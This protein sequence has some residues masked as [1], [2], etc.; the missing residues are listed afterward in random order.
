MRRHAG[1]RRCFASALSTA[2]VAYVQRIT[3]VA[4][5]QQALPPPKAAVAFVQGTAGVA[6]YQKFVTAGVGRYKK[7]CVESEGI[8]G[9]AGVAGVA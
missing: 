8:T 1:N 4:Y 6:R 3:S 2:G 7:A 5:M 9:V